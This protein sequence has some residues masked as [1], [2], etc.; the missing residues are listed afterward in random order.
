MLDAKDHATS[1]CARQEGG[2]S[3]VQD[4]AGHQSPVSDDSDWYKDPDGRWRKKWAQ[5]DEM[6]ERAERRTWQAYL[7]LVGNGRRVV[8]VV[9]IV[10]HSSI[11]Y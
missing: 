11:P 1:T 4:R 2:W 7:C 9:V 8:I 5:S 3:L 10:P 6:P